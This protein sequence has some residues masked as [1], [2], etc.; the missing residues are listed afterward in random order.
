MGGEIQARPL[1]LGR[2]IFYPIASPTRG[3]CPEFCPAKIETNALAA[4]GRHSLHLS[5]FFRPGSHL[6][7]WS[8][9]GPDSPPT[10][11]PRSCKHGHFS[12]IN[13]QHALLLGYCSGPSSWKKLIS[14]S[15]D[16]LFAL[17]NRCLM[18]WFRME[19]CA[20]LTAGYVAKGL[21]S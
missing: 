5:L 17:T 4:P 10:P 11:Q 18:A 13:Q 20:P 12:S 1:H 6:R 14:L 9:G 3:F 7:P 8:S 21:Q 2:L 16:T 15:L 19:A